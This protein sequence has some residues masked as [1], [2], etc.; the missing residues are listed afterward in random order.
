M[1]LSC[2]TPKPQANPSLSPPFPPPS[3]DAGKLAFE[4]LKHLFGSKDLRSNRGK[5]YQLY[6]SVWEV[7]TDTREL[8]TDLLSSILDPEEAKGSAGRSFKAIH[9]PTLKHASTI[10]SSIPSKVTSSPHKANVFVRVLLR[11]ELANSTSAVHFIDMVSTS[12]TSD[13]KI[14]KGR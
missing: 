12:E 13:K 1:I 8:V 9:I 14:L 6:L 3:S 2:F 5:E 7:G 4:T 11:S 10:L